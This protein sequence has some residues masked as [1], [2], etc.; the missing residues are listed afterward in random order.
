VVTGETQGRR[1]VVVGSGPSGFYCADQLLGEGFLVDVIDALPTPFGLVRAG[2]APD[3]PKIKAVTRVYDR[4]AGKQGFRF[5]GGVE[6]GADVT[7]EELLDR[8]HVV[9]YAFGAADDNKLGVPGED[10]PGS[11]GAARFVA[12]YNGHPRG[13]DDEF[14]LS[15]E[16]AVVV[17]NG[18]VAIDIARMLVLDPDELAVT[19]I[20]DHALEALAASTVRE[21]VVLGRRGPAQ[22]AFSNPE[23]RE[24][25]HLK[26]ADVVID[27][28][29]LELDTDS[30]R[31]LDE[32]AD[33]SARIN[34]EVMREYAAS[35]P[36]EGRLR[37][38]LK[39]LAS[40]VEIVG[41]GDDGP[42]TGVRIA[43]N[44]I[45]TSADGRLS[46][47]P[48]EH[49]EII[50]CGLV[51]RSIG[52]RGR[53][54]AG[55]PFDERRGLIRNAAGRVVDEAGLHHT[56]EYVVGWIKRGPSGVIGT[57][58]KDAT[59]TVE[60][61]REDVAAGRVHQ[62]S[63]GAEDPGPWLAGRGQAVGWDGWQAIDAHERAR[64]EPQGRPRVK[65]V[66]LDDL[67]AHARVSG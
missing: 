60:C 36:A 40:P 15:A 25:A 26:R 39:F 22:A 32:D 4:I 3:H 38:V 37:V 24:L 29:E 66:R 10:R 67:H 27:A 19:D 46:A 28:A 11:Y 23:L 51:L 1:A 16:R 49:E 14:V 52:Y 45:E 20:A 56:G 53:P 9:V 7:R 33:P 30:E 61:I 13:V 41:D 12:W 62:P 8:Y 35:E 31:W 64:G 50:E 59:D 57:N 42:V 44:R 65:V 43:R 47:V 54:T 5:F 63:L 34:V 2:V 21:V 55:L 6:L 18:N 48:T 58:R 17:G